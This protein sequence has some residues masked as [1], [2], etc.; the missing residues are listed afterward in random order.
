MRF[1]LLGDHPDGLDMAR[2]LVESG[3][4]QLAVYAGPVEGL[5]RLSR[6]ELRPRLMGDLEEVLA[7][8]GIEAVI[9]AGRLD[10]R[11]LELRRALQSAH[12]VLCVHPVDDSPDSA[13]EAAMLQNDVK[14]VL[15]PLLPQRFHP[16]LRRLAE[17]ATGQ[18]RIADC[19]FQVAKPETMAP[20]SAIR[21][22]PSAIGQRLIELE[23][24]STA[25]VLPEGE[26]LAHKSGLPGWDF[27]RFIGGEIAEIFALAFAEETLPEE[28]LLVVGKFQA[29]GLFQA[30]F[31]P[32]QA[33]PRWR[34][35]VVGRQGKAE[36][37]FAEG[38]PG[39]ARLCWLDE[40]GQ[41]HMENFQTWNPWPALVTEFEWA[42]LRGQGSGTKGQ[43]GTRGQESGFL[44]PGPSPLTPMGWQDEIR[45]LE[46]DDAARRSLV[47]GRSSSA[48]EYQEATEAVGFKG[49]MTLL[50]CGLLLASVL[51]LILSAWS[52]WLGWAILPLI[53]LFLVLQLLRLLVP[54][55]P[56]PGSRPVKPDETV[57]TAPAD[58]RITAG[59]PGRPVLPPKWE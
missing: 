40:A 34:L 33:E 49:T 35:A 38:W 37:T 45:C 23:I 10:S 6:W 51:F 54:A 57:P 13:Y 48:L 31:L 2:A 16:G 55:P 36:L 19:R 46:L 41:A 39:P 25:E 24:W 8:P 53:G 4:H 59:E 22:P 44:T 29:G 11:P 3:R 52:P 50:G 21:H 14:K 5:E 56:A 58:S 42:V 12:H 20:P 28:P 17:L 47:S 18:L 32:N 7:D 27:L 30:A 1:A 43:E 26:S 9:V 15:L